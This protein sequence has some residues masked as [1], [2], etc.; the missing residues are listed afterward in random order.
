MMSPTLTSLN[1]S[2]R[3]AALDADLHLADVV[4]EPAQRASLPF[5]TTTPSR[6][7]ARLRVA[8]ARDAA[9]GDHAA[10]DRAGLRRLEDLPHLGRRRCRVSLSVGSS[11]PGHRLLHLVG[12]VVDDRVM[13]DVD[14]LAVGHL[15]GVAIRLH[16]EADDDRVRRRREQHVRLVDRADARVDRCGS[17]RARRSASPACR[18][19]LRPSPARRP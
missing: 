13:P 9:V 4:L 1:R 19:A 14:L 8:A 16:V 2:R 6:S 12:H 15:G 3:D 5:Q 17:S 18:P 11:R 7:E 10:G